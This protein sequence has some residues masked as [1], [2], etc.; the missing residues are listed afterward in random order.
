VH[1][2]INYDGVLITH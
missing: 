2:E 1:F